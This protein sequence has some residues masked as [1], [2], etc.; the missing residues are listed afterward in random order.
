MIRKWESLGE[1][2][3]VKVL[4]CGEALVICLSRYENMISFVV[5]R[6]MGNSAYFCGSLRY[7]YGHIIALIV[8]A[9][10]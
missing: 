1:V 7:L 8:L 3:D 2:S 10:I 4:R 6:Q 5:L 9:G